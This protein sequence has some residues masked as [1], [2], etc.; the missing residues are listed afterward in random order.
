MKEGV[1]LNDWQASSS[2]VGQQSRVLDLRDYSKLLTDIFVPQFPSTQAFQD[3]GLHVKATGVLT[4]TDIFLACLQSGRSNLL[5]NETS[6]ILLKSVGLM[7]DIFVD[8]KGEDFLSHIEAHGAPILDADRSH[9]EQQLIL[10]LDD[11]GRLRIQAFGANTL[12]LLDDAVAKNGP[13]IFRGGVIQHQQGSSLY[14][15]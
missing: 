9:S 11:G 4:E 15:P 8:E 2:K 5:P 10:H 13:F 6:K 3:A 1:S 7:D 12:G 14:S